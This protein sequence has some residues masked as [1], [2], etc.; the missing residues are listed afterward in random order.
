MTSS[1]DGTGGRG[2]TAAGGS[3]VSRGGAGGTA[4][5][6]VA[7]GGR[8]GTGSSGAA[9]NATGAMA[10][11][12]GTT[13][14]GGISGAGG[15]AG[16]AGTGAS[17]ATGL[18]G[19]SGAGGTTGTGG[20]AARGG[21][22]GGSG[23]GTTASG[24]ISGAGGTA[25]TAGTGASG[26]T[27][28]GGMSGAGGT[29]GTGGAAAR[30]GTSGGSGGGAATGGA[31]GTNSCPQGGAVD[32]SSGGALKLTPAGQVTSFS[33]VDWNSVSGLWCDAQGLG[34]SIFAY[35]AATDGP[36]TS[37]RAVV[38]TTAQ[39]LRFD[40]AVLQGSSA[41]GG[42]L[43]DSCVNAS[44]FNAVQF[45]A[46]ITSGSLPG[47][48]WQVLLLTQDQRPVTAT[49]P[50]GGTCTS[51]CY[52]LPAFAPATIPTATATTFVA[53]F[54]GFSNPSGSA[55]AAPTQIVGLQWQVNSAPGAC[56]VELRIDNIK[57]V[58]Q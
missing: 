4:G 33:A 44:T 42:L 55:I 7:N 8:A 17:G 37:A 36:T 5:S 54:S 15:T 16:T 41:G 6:I 56:T 30:G 13:A 38:D 24:G 46:A 50:T 53:P 47:C 12:G 40:L 10:G 14:S 58:S 43:F 49:D 1:Y 32:C 25:G 19:M 39:N 35:P 20:A 34:G 2:G 57:F 9:G 23:G 18:G 45:T 31:M 27:G 52:R 51:N 3:N 29:T 28:L 48:D 21:T 26:A 22:S 11:I